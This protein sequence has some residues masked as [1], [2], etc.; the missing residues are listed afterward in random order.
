MLSHMTSS[1]CQFFRNWRDKAYFRTNVQTVEYYLRKK[2]IKTGSAAKDFPETNCG[3]TAKRR[4]R[5]RQ[6]FHTEN[7]IRSAFYYRY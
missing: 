2:E 3:I 6:E 7:G 5:R 1:E 4:N